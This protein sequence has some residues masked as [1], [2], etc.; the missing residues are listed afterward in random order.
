MSTS[1][2]LPFFSVI[3]P[4]YGRFPQLRECL[5]AFNKLDYPISKFEVIVVNDGYHPPPDEVI[6][7]F[8]KQFDVRLISQKHSGPAAARNLGTSIAK[9]DYY[10]FTDDD[11]L[12]STRWLQILASRFSERPETAIGGRTINALPKN[13]FSVASQAVLEVVFAYFNS[14][15]DHAEFVATNNMAVP[16][17]IFKSIGGFHEEFTTSEDRELCDRWRHKGLSLI[18]DPEV[19]VHH[20]NPLT[21]RGFCK[22]HFNYGRGAHR[23]HAL[24]AKRNSGRLKPD[25]QFYTKLLAYPFYEGCKSPWLVATLTFAS[26]VANVSGYFWQSV[27][28]FRDRASSVNYR[29]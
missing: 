8:Q 29:L 19:L 28:Q 17:P 10:A 18:Y 9:G 12:V 6:L 4:S 11:C 26:Q 7:P 24:R 16:A 22:Q 25:L 5:G 21:F 23:F 2:Q 3:I 14:D 27:T 13:H 20:A 1:E 15:P